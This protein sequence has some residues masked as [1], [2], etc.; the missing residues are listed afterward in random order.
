MRACY[1]RELKRK[2]NLRGKVVLGWTIRADGHVRSAR[3]IRDTTG[4]AG[5]T[6]CIV[7]AVGAWRFPRAEAGQDIEYPFSFKP[8]DY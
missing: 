2:P 7:K 1:E 8:R 6:R 4:N 3:A 5:M